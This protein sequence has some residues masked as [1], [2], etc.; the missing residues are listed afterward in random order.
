[1][2]LHLWLGQCTTAWNE[3]GIIA[4]KKMPQ[5]AKH[6]CS[7]RTIFKCC[8]IFKCF[9]KDFSFQ[10]W[11]PFRL[12]DG[13]HTPWY[14]LMRHMVKQLGL[15]HGQLTKSAGETGGKGASGRLQRSPAAPGRWQAIEVES[16]PR[17]RSRGDV[18]V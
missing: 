8:H 1:M 5:A 4:R 11:K 10:S 2:H 17:K 16:L 18:F 6:P 9:F 3:L 15:W 12:F 7:K 14:S 13:G